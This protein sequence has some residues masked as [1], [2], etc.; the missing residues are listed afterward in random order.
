MKWNG[1]FDT[2]EKNNVSDKMFCFI[3]PNEEYFV[4][5]N[6][7]YVEVSRMLLMK[8]GMMYEHLID[9]EPLDNEP[10]FMDEF[11]VGDDLFAI[12]LEQF[13]FTGLDADALIVNFIL[14]EQVLRHHTEEALRN[15]G[16][17]TRFDEEI[18]R[19]GNVICKVQISM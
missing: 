5:V 8:G 1:D 9:L 4:K 12:N 13:H 14:N 17:D 15:S 3:Q 16:E 7:Q 19:S 2:N 10:T 6:V 11:L 18:L